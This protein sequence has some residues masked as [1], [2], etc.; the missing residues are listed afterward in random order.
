MIHVPGAIVFAAF[1]LIGP[2]GIRHAADTL[3][4]FGF[5]GCA[6]SVALGSNRS[7]HRQSAA[8]L[9]VLAVLSYESLQS[10]TAW[11]TIELTE[12]PILGEREALHLAPYLFFT[13]NVGLAAIGVV[14][15]V[16]AAI[17]LEVRKTRFPLA[18]LFPET[19]FA[20]APTELTNS[21][22]R[23]A[24]A[25]GVTPPH[26]SLI[27]TGS[28]AA[29]VTRSRRGFELAISV[30]LIE[31]LGVDEVEACIAHELSHM[32]NND[33]AVRTFATSAR[34]ALFAHPLSHFVEPA[35]Y[36]AR[37]FLADKTAVKLLGGSNSLIS[38][39]SKIHE[40]QSYVTSQPGS[41]T[42]ACLFDPPSRGRFV[43]LFD[44]HPSLDAR[45]KALRELNLHD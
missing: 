11:L 14:A 8:L 18:K 43:R 3:I 39:L 28:P 23:I 15:A 6:L 32:K 22:A 5:M 45:I 25:A 17:Y 24:R 35:L 29:F 36:R 40:S 19:N 1:L 12:V 27:D 10:I 21:A 31:S 37:E 4:L 7:S 13:V 20:T 16:I 30:G 41:V 9:F 34:V 44:K 33:F 2:F 42:T 38:A 26:V